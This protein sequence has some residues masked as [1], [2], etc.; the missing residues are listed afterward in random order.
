MR[1]GARR[2]RRLP[3]RGTARPGV[4]IAI[5]LAVLPALLAACG[6]APS[7]PSALAATRQIHVSP[8]K[9]DGSPAA[10]FRTT[11]TVG[12]A[13]CE[14]GSEAIGQAYRCSAGNFL[15]DPCWAE[16]AARPTVLCLAFPWLST[17]IRL[18]LSA[19]LAAMPNEGGLN[20]PWGVQLA[21]GQRCALLQGAHSEFD[22]R[23]IDY[24]CNS[25]L[26]LL[27]G[28]TKTSAVWLAASVIEKGGKQAS[29]PPERIRIAWF[30]RPST[31]R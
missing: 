4:R 5:A 8:V 9:A 29:G 21:G 11:S 7:H 18:S 2:A 27:R 25:Q 1:A 15:Y 3:G 23:V 20:E 6:A 19:P 17:V 30:G 14:P 12:R 28:L 26:S 16:R 22:S 10:G 24:Y 13:L 31:F